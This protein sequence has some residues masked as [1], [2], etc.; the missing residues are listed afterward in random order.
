M[1]KTIVL[2]D[3]PVD[4][5]ASMERWYYRDHSSEIARRY[6]PWLQRHE[7]YVAINAPEDARQ[8]GFYN[9]RLTECYWRE[10][11][12]PGPKG[13]LCYTPPPVW[14]PVATCAVP[15]QPTEDFL[16]WDR[17]PS[18]GAYIRWVMMFRYPLGVRLEDGEDWYLNVHA[19]EI[20]KQP[21]LRR[22]ISYKVLKPPVALPGM[23][24][25]EHS[26]PDN[27]MMVQWDRV[28]ELWY[29]SFSAWRK[30]VIESPPQYTLPEWATD[31]FYPNT[32]D[33]FP[34]FKPGVDLVS[35]FLLERPADEFLRD[36]RHYVP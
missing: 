25:P 26:P 18:D 34:F 30:A 13:A 5:I 27:M 22:F 33:Y 32:I 1:L 17:F 3:L 21:G 6:G 20:M 28:T 14:N 2:M 4:N 24:H 7:S 15:A 35:T 10:L 8:Y 16:G 12:E 31:P 23:W 11:P 36:I 19:P 9:W 29:D